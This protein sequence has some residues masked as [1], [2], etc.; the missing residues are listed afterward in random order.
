MKYQL[1]MVDK[2]VLQLSKM[3]TSP[4]HYLREDVVY[5]IHMIYLIVIANPK[6]LKLLMKR[7]VH[8]IVMIITYVTTLFQSAKLTFTLNLTC[9]L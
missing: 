5:Q 3:Q 1:K 9:T 2:N 6:S 4:A 8:V 7:L